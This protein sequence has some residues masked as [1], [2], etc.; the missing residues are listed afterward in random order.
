MNQGMRRASLRGNVSGR[1]RGGTVSSMPRSRVAKVFRAVA[2]G[3]AG[4]L[5][6]STILL[7]AVAPASAA[8]GDFT[9][10]LDAPATVPVGQSFNYT[11]TLD[12]EGPAATHSGVVLT[13]TL[14]VGTEFESCPIGGSSP[15]A[16]CTYDAATRALTIAL[17][18]TQTD[19][20][21]VAYTVRQAPYNDR[22]EGEVLATSITGSGGPSGAVTSDTVETVLTGS[23]QYNASK[24]SQVLL[25]SDNRTVTYTFNVSVGGP[26]PGTF[27]SHAQELTDTF[28]AG[29]ELVSTSSGVGSWDVSSFP[30]VVWNRD[31][32]YFSTGALDMSGGAIS[33]TVRY[34]ES[35]FPGE[36]APPL[37]TVSL[38]TQDAN[39]VWHDGAPASAQAPV[40]AEGSG[41]PAVAAAKVKAYGLDT[42]GFLQH[43]VRATGSYIGNAGAPN[44]DSLVLEDSGATGTENATW[45]Q[46]MDVQNFTVSFNST[47]TAANLPYSF[48]YQVN[49]ST[50]WQTV[51][52][53]AGTGTSG[54]FSTH[55]AGSEGWGGG[56]PVDLAAG[57]T[58]S[59]WRIVV[60]PGA[61]T[62]PPGSEVTVLMG[63]QPVFRTI[64]EGIV[65]TA[66]AAGAPVGSVPNT[67]TVRNGDSSVEDTSTY[68]FTPL[69]SV[70]LTTIISGP[71][72]LSVGGTGTYRAS[73][74]NQNPSE[75]YTDSVM[76]V[77]LPCGILYDPSQPI[78]PDT[79]PVVGV[80]SPAP[81]IGSGVTVDTS[82]RVLDA[83]GCEQ[84]VVEFTFD[85]VP[86]MR[87]PGVANN[88]YV[89]NDG[90]SYD[91]PVTVLAQ[92]YDPA[93]TALTPQS[94]AHTN[95]PRFL[96]V[97]DGGTGTTTVPML[98]YGGFFHEDTNNFDPARSAIAY[99]QVLTSVNT[100]GGVLID[101]LSS[102][103]AEG[104]Y[105]LTSPVNEDAFWR[106]FVSNVLPGTVSNAVFFDKLPAVADGDD[107]AVTLTGPVT[108][109]PAGATVEYST[110]ATSATTGTW[111][112][113]PAGAT[114]FRVTVPTI[115][116]GANFTLIV[117]TS[118]DGEAVAA[119]SADNEISAT[120]VYG[121]NPVA[122]ESNEATVTIAATP[123]ISIVKT[124]NGIDVP[125]VD[126]A[127][128]VP[129]GSNV[130]WGYVVAN[131]GNTV[132]TGVTVADIGGASG[133]PGA[134]VNVV[135][136]TGFDGTL[137]VGE[138]VT[139]TATG[140]AITGLYEN[141]AT[142]TGVPS[143][144]EGIPI[145]DAA[146]VTAADTSWYTG[147]EV[148][149]SIVKQV[150]L[151]DDGP[152][153]ETVTAPAGTTIYWSI[154]V[155]NT[156][157]APLTNV[158]VSDPLA[159]QFEEQTIPTLAAGET[160]T[161]VVAHT[162]T[163]P[164]TN[165][166]T[167]S[168]DVGDDT[169]IVADNAAA[170]ITA[171]PPTP[172]TPTPAN[173]AGKP[174]TGSLPNTGANVTIGLA[175][176]L[177]LLLAGGIALTVSRRR[178]T[179]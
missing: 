178:R 74:I 40:F 115:A 133:A 57:E 137:E 46:H 122:F 132:L 153:S 51:A 23:N 26:I 114:A 170:A 39:G 120:A 143:D 140:T 104:P 158:V 152:W 174:G 15:I 55:V 107:F 164:L 76:S 91:I 8:D 86:P 67:L 72:S 98:G 124:T 43:T 33:V 6:S 30:T 99:S 32:V 12:F 64:D 131:T 87:A 75:I 36:V 103:T 123:G 111:T 60:A 50:T 138:S 47:L 38:R 105:A 167:A 31:D 18:D 109:V 24:G 108:G 146:P 25:G 155:T 101:K 171:A 42:A 172:T 45:Y 77:L 148:G 127:P 58:I 135:A 116:T 88:R 73:L 49:G 136:P 169:V 150:S 54:T 147:G 70:Y 53:P 126:D 175:A 89:E 176:L 81:A 154:A 35:V 65:D 85:E 128:V 37:N 102:A 56:T 93:N 5:A 66:T 160:R 68:E 71:S 92:A 29:V 144:E 80:P 21:S 119:Q 52:A 110:D 94:W 96:S 10:A 22:Y 129:T 139:F 177:G 16:S 20:L 19:P 159:T 165:V 82:K 141:T 113:T 117:P 69:D 121:G 17:N 4:I 84:Q 27:A 83:N 59:G 62:V 95:D 168:V 7:G 163:G 100:A 44:I 14:P 48:E 28:P 79:T 78:V 11:A 34:P 118:V 125:T 173:P 166:A 151:N 130:Q 142:A 1:G 156:G 2:L 157:E 145:P 97:A 149:L 112:T 179:N 162:L 90:W 3:V 63:G 161:F 61:E 106:I 13:T 9:I 134:T 41:D